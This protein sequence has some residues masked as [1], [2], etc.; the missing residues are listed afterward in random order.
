MAISIQEYLDEQ[1]QEVHRVA[2]AGGTLSVEAFVNFAAELLVEA[3]ELRDFTYAPLIGQRGLTVHGYDS[4]PKDAD[5]ILT[6]VIAD[7]V[8]ESPSGTLTQ[9]DLDALLRR[10]TNFVAQ[11][12]DEDFRFEMEPSSPAWEL[13]DLINV[14]WPYIEKVRVILVTNKILSKRVDGHQHG[15]V[16]GKRV[17]YS[18]WDLSRFHQLELSNT[19]REELIIDLEE[20]FGEG[21]PAIQANLPGSNYESFLVVVPG[22]HLAAIYDRWHDRLLEQNVRVFL[23]AKSNV[24]RGIRD[25]IRHRPEMFFAYNNGIS[26]T[27]ESVELAEDDFGYQITSFRNLQIVN[28]GQTTASIHAARKSDPEQLKRV[29]VQ[30]K[31]SIIRP[32]DAMEVVPKISEYANSQNTVSKADFFSNHPFHVQIENASRRINAPSADGTFRQSKWFYERARGQYADARGSLTKANRDKFDL[33]YPRTQF[34][35]KTDLAK[36][37][38]V[39]RLIPQEVSKGAQKIFQHFAGYVDTEWDRNQAQFNDAKY[40]EYIA[41]AIIFKSTE[42]LVSKATW[43]EGGYRANIVAYGISKLAWEVGKMGYR[44]DF[45]RVW[46]EQAISESLAAAIL[47][48][49]R[50]AQDIILQPKNVRNISEWAKQDECWDILRDTPVTLPANLT[51]VL[52]DTGKATEK[53]NDDIKMGKIDVGIQNQM[54]VMNAGT[55]FWKKVQEWGNEYRLLGVKD[56]SILRIA[57]D[58]TKFPSEKQSAH[59]VQ[60]IARLEKEGLPFADEI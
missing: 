27:A 4:D 53:T 41:K 57:M 12:L 19:G 26:A 47:D 52:I 33:E 13:A 14:R 55:P 36:F 17:T 22:P 25:T 49:S 31:L 58:P 51:D 56:L 24:N 9:T 28:G 44:V 43:Y 35:G 16:D 48:C 20:E 30:M 5:N 7:Y 60:M 39:W 40:R 50:T 3:G 21:F 23:Q 1:L 45:D 37:D 54:R 8:Q 18:V 11:S 6:V 15:E 29:S 38:S 32:E 59:L 2:L 46:K 34:F 10:A 42:R